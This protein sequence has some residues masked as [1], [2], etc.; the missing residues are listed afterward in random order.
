MGTKKG[1]GPDGGTARA[2]GEAEVNG[3]ENPSLVFADYHAGNKAQ[4]GLSPG[5]AGAGDHQSV[6]GSVFLSETGAPGM[7][8]QLSE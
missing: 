3:R 1:R 8:K 6:E 2:D 5:E 7:Q 4:A